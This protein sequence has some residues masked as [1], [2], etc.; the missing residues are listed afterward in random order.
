MDSI[1]TPFEAARQHFDKDKVSME[2]RY[3][4]LLYEDLFT[5]PMLVGLGGQVDGHV[6]RHVWATLTPGLVERFDAPQR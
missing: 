4:Q 1:P 3:T 5:V 2:A 6:V